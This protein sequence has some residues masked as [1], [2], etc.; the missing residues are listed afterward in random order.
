MGYGAEPE[1]APQWLEEGRRL[2]RGL[3]FFADGETRTWAWYS[4]RVGQQLTLE[5]LRLW[6]ARRAASLCV[7]CGKPQ[8]DANGYFCTFHAAHAREHGNLP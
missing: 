5:G 1:L 3:S 8:R 4:V 2:W 6:M 7:V